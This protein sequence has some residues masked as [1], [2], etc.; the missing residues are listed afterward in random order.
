[1]RSEGGRE[2]FCLSNREIR[3]SGMGYN[4]R[5]LK[6]LKAKKEGPAS[7]MR[8]WRERKRERREGKVL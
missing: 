2:K 6:Y 3:R 5:Q 8:S 4:K 1:M 7:E